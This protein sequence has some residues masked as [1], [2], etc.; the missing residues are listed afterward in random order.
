NSETRPDI[1]VVV[2]A[3]CS[4]QGSD[5]AAPIFRRVLEYYF[6]DK[7]SRL[8]PWESTFFVT[9]TPTM[10]PTETPYGGEQT[11]EPGN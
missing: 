3:E 2:L 5:I 4:G 8:Y 7:P 9:S 6:Y 10:E 1:A 11:P